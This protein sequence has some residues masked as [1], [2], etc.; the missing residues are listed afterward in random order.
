MS[1]TRQLL[2]EFRPLFRVLDEP[3]GRAPSV[4]STRSSPFD[5]FW[6]SGPSRPHLAMDVTDK[7]DKYLV[8]A[9]LPGVPKEN[10]EVKVGDGGRSITIEGQSRYVSPSNAQGTANQSSQSEAG[11]SNSFLL[12]SF[13]H[14]LLS[15]QGIGNY[16]R[17]STFRAPVCW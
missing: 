3:F 11:A 8:E 16:K 17:S 13:P 12:I 2:N 4:F 1:I 15:Y 10:I 9:D 14:T 7:G 5:D 6:R